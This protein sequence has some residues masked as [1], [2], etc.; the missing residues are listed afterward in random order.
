MRT[1]LLVFLFVFLAGCSAVTVKKVSPPEPESVVPFVFST[2]E[3]RFLSLDEFAEVLADSDAVF[4]GEFHDQQGCHNFEFWAVQAFCSTQKKT[5]IGMEMFQRPFQKSLD[6]FVDEVISEEQMLKETEFESRWGF[7]YDFYAPI[8]RFCRDRGV[9]L[10]ALNLRREVSNRI[11]RKGLSGLSPRE[12]TLLPENMDLSNEAHRRFVL[13]NFEGMMR[14]GILTQEKVKN[15]YE[16]Q[17]AWD[18][19]MAETAASALCGEN[20]SERILVLAGAAHISHRFTIP[21]RFK[22]RSGCDYISVLPQRTGI[23]VITLLKRY[24]I[25]VCDYVYFFIPTEATGEE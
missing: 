6:H 4:I 10:V 22:R 5:C 19:T 17:V 23:D 8:L 12:R 7:D 21:E 24:T 18:E 25:D 14:R 2:K 15:F 20:R 16:A 13:K 9:R 1:L 11:A 3:K